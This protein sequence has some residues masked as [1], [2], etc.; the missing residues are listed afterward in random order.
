MTVTA[1]YSQT[2]N[3]ITEVINAVEG[4]KS[5]FHTSTNLGSVKVWNFNVNVPTNI[6]KWWFMNTYAEM[7]IR[8][9]QDAE[10][11]NLTNK[12]TFAVIQSTNQFTLPKNFKL[13]TTLFFQSKI[14]VGNIIVNPLMN[15][16][17]A[18]QKSFKDNKFNIK[19]NVTDILY[20][21]KINANTPTTGLDR[22]TFQRRNDSRALYL[23]FTYNFDRNNTGS[24][25]G[26]NTGLDEE[27]RRASGGR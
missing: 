6:T 5:T 17:F 4:S 26:R 2:N 12:N 24:H 27:N 21:M 11:A 9:Q 16:S 8:K 3:F 20:T 18:I 1:S 19:A 25:K 10:S 13:E 7:N 23:T 22:N 14:R 15:W